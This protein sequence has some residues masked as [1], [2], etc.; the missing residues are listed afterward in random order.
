MALVTGADVRFAGTT[1]GLEAEL[2]PQAGYRLLTLPASGFR[3]L[4]SKARLLFLWNFLRGFLRSLMHLVG[5]RPAVVLGTG[6]YVSA[7]VMAAAR[8]LGIPCALQE[9]NAIPGSTNRLVGRWA[10]RI[11]LGFGDAARYFKSGVSLETGNPVRA[12]FLG[13]I[14]N[15]TTSSG[16]GKSVLL[17]GGSGG[18]ASLNRAVAQAA[19]AWHDRR[20]VRFLMQTGRRHTA[21]VLAAYA[22]FPGDAVQVVPYIDDMA[23]ALGRADLVVCRAGAMTLAELQ[24]MGKPA[25]LVP[26]PHATD[27]HQLRNAEDCARAGAA[28]VLPDDQC[29]GP[30]LVRV[31]DKL[32][33]DPAELAKMATAAR[34]LA[35]PR[36][37]L[38]IAGDLLALAGHPAGQW[39]DPDREDPELVP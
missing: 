14:A 21:D 18:A 3:G 29:D 4:G 2:V 32:L 13:G 30:T 22:A 24:S 38:N 39:M 23:A 7:P 36:A 9:Q 27:D 35:R 12:A 1:R 26:F 5:W 28:V 19:A 16:Q 11:Y 37:A 10:R 34:S 15:T 17:C 6:G 25:V 8:L 31:V 20:D 33:N